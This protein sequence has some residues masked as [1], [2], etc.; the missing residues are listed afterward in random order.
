MSDPRTPVLGNP[1]FAGETGDFQ[2][3]TEADV[4]GSDYVAHRPLEGRHAGAAGSY[5]FQLVAK[6]PDAP[7]FD[8]AYRVRVDKL[9][10]RYPTP[11]GALLPVLSL[12]QE[13]RGHLSP[14]TMAHVAATLGLSPTAVQ[15]NERYFENVTPEAVPP[16][17]DRLRRERREGGGRH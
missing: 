5:P 2:Q 7:L 13:I 1:G 9:I 11:Q 8:G 4:R 6:Q 10:S 17:L 16:I 14:E 15:I 3:L 12:A